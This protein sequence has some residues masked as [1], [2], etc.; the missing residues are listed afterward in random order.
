MPNWKKVITSGSDAVLSSLSVANAIT[1]SVFSGSHIGSLTGTASWATNALSADQ[2][3]TAVQATSATTVQTVPVTSG[4]PNVLYPTFVSSSN[5]NAS[6]A[7]RI[8]SAFTYITSSNTLTVTASQAITASIASTASYVLN[9]VSSSR[10][11]TAASSDVSYAVKTAPVSGDRNFFVSYLNASDSSFQ[12]LYSTSS[13]TYNP[14]SQ[15]LNVTASRAVTASHA[16]TASYVLNSVSASFATSASRAISSSWS[17]VASSSIV[18]DTNINNTYYLTFTSNAGQSALLTDTSGITYNPSTNTLSG[19]N[20]ESPIYVYGTGANITT[21]PVFIDTQ[22]GNN[23]SKLYVTQ[24][25]S[26]NTQTNTLTVPKLT[27][28]QNVTVTGSLN[29]TGSVIIAGSS[30]AAALME[31]IRF[32]GPIG[33]LAPAGPYVLYQVPTASYNTIIF[34]YSAQS[35]SWLKM[36]TVPLIQSGSTIS[37]TEYGTTS[38]GTVASYNVIGSVSNGN[39]QVLLSTGTSGI[40]IKAIIRSM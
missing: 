28:T 3:T 13:F 34:E 25:Y 1:A 26:Y 11:T 8:R 36:G 5:G 33:P 2:A 18:T 9:A 32:T 10:A 12:D 21:Y 23:F 17:G 19:S 38:I 20:I 7:L 4:D 24:S 22:I 31:T 37:Y 15:S 30:S 16:I 35:G 6:S 39:L 14:V 29:V 27:A 40:S